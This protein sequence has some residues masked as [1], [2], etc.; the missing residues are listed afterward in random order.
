MAQVRRDLGEGMTTWRTLCFQRRVKQQVTTRLRCWNRIQSPSWNLT[1]TSRSSS[2]RRRRART[3]NPP[4][5]WMPMI[6]IALPR[7]PSGNHRVST[8]PLS[9]PIGLD[10]N[11]NPLAFDHLAVSSKARRILSVKS[12]RPYPLRMS[13]LKY[14]RISLSKN[15]DAWNE[16]K[17]RN[18][19]T[20]RGRNERV[21]RH[22]TEKMESVVV[23]S[24]CR[25]STP[26]CPSLETFS[27]SF[28]SLSFH[29]ENQYQTDTSITQH[30]PYGIG[31]SR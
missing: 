5:N 13:T 7:M 9:T 20:D 1:I 18:E 4:Y 11:P 14:I 3:M 19:I 23:A 6:L 30:F 31:I 2:P 25:R 15:F 8:N 12:K 21:L 10:Y 17:V 28:F 24:S 22:F 27:V 29:I 26:F 16:L